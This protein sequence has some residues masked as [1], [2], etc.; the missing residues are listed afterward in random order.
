MTKEMTIY[1]TDV[2]RQR[3]GHLI[4][5][6]R[7]EGEKADFSYIRQLEEKLELAEAV[8]P[9]Q[10][11][12]DVVTMR[13]KVSLKDLDT[14]KRQVYSIV[15]PLE[16]NTEE[17]KISILAPL[18]TALLGFKCGDTVEVQAPSRLRRLKIEEILYQP[19]SAGDFNL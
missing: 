3:L 6:V 4:E 9:E 14:G 12:S 2:D 19:E 11:P 13:S 16:A 15:F 8:A 10:I 5:R 18:A 7:N 1:T 17:G